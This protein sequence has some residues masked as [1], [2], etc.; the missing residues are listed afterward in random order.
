MA[1]SRESG[2]L[3]FTTGI[4][5]QPTGIGPGTP[6]SH[7]NSHGSHFL[8]EHIYLSVYCSSIFFIDN[9]ESYKQISCVIFQHM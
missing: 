8:T 5:L 9:K 1:L 7:L 6:G 2:S 4:K 3:P